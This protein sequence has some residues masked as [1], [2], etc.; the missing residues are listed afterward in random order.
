MPVTVLDLPVSDAL[1]LRVPVPVPGFGA[2]AAPIQGA[3]GRC[4]GGPPASPGRAHAH[5]APAPPRRAPG[6]PAPP[7]PGWSFGSPGSALRGRREAAAARP[8]PTHGFPGLPEEC[9]AR[10]ARQSRVP[11]ARSFSSSTRSRR[12]RGRAL[13]SRATGAAVLRRGRGRA[14]AQEASTLGPIRPL[15][16]ESMAR[17]NRRSHREAS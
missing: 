4:C 11:F 13:Q 5:Q 6:L 17:P 1:P 7:A 16:A 12:T 2:G 10:G 8:V 9:W 14:Q 15:M 3:R